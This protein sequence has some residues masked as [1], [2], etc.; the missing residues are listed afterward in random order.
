MAWYDD[1]LAAWDTHQGARVVSFM[2][3]DAVYGDVALGVEHKGIDD[4]AA[5]ID[6]M[7]QTLSS[8]YRFEPVSAVDTPSAYA[9]E[10]VLKG[11]HDKTS[12]QLPATG[13][14][15]AIRGASV[16]ALRD[17]KIERNTDYWTMTEFL[18]QIGVMPPPNVG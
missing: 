7:E 16:G 13:K 3:P 10:W 11:T 2:T 6:E 5:W 4:I 14:Q 18:I 8:D 1:Y 15:F 12:P 9:L 17:G